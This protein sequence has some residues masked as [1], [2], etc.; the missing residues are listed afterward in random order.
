MSLN[1]G[2]ID[3]ESS[4][5]AVLK[6]AR[7]QRGVSLEKMASHLRLSQQT[8]IDI[9]AD[10]PPDNV[11]PAYW[12]GYYRSYALAM[13]LDPSSIL[14]PVSS[15]DHSAFVSPA[16]GEP[17]TKR[18]LSREKSCGT[19]TAHASATNGGCFCCGWCYCFWCVV[20][21]PPA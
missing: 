6:R 8:V 15:K 17:S 20:V 13:G 16:I 18:T 10:E 9:E 4:P 3:S 2:S 14:P 11:P 21:T 12:R 7:E 1:H 19:V 5:G